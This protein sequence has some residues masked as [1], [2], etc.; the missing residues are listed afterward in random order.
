MTMAHTSQTAKNLPGQEVRLSGIGLITGQTIEVTLIKPSEATGIRFFYNDIIIPATDAMVVDTFR[1]VTLAN[2]GQTLSIVEHFLAACAMAGVLHLDVYLDGPA[3]E[4]PLL[5]GSALPWVSAIE[6]FVDPMPTT[7][8]GLSAPVVHVDPKDPMVTITGA[9]CDRLIVSYLLDFPHPDLK[10]RWFSFEPG[11]YGW[12]EA[13]APARTFGFVRELPMLQEQGLARGV[14]I[15]NTL[16][17]TDEG[18]Y[19]TPLRMPDEPLRHKILDFVGDLMLCGLPIQ[20]LRGHFIAQS[21]G[22]TSH[23]AFGRMLKSVL[24]PLP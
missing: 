6:R 2:Q 7:V 16:G 12:V 24:V 4:L 15:D 21:A 3:P 17:L 9:P 8:Y 10:Q 22:H 1:G 23:V 19:T 14:S 13:I 18:S 11:A 5:D 20:T